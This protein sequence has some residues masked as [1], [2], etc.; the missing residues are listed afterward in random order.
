MRQNLQKKIDQPKDK[1]FLTPIVFFVCVYF[2][3][4]LVVESKLI[5]HSFGMFCKTP[6]FSK[7]MSFFTGFLQYPGGIIDYISAMLSQLYYHSYLGALIITLVAVA[8]YLCTKKLINFAGGGRSLNFVCYIPVFMMLI[9]YN[10]YYHSLTTYLAIL[11][12]LLFSVVHVKISRRID[13]LHLVLFVLEFI[14]LYYVAAGVASLFVIIT[15]AYE[16]FIRRRLISSMLFL[17]TV[18]IAVWF[19]G[20]YYFQLEIAQSCLYLTPFYK[21][22]YIPL[23]KNPAKIINICLYLF[24]PVA[25]LSVMLWHSF[26][27]QKKSVPNNNVGSY[28]RSRVVVST[29][30]LVITS[31]ATVYLSFN[32]NA[33]A[34]RQTIYL[35][36]HKMWSEL[37]AH[38]KNL[39]RKHHHLINT[40]CANRALY[41]T[42]RLAEDMFSYPQ[43]SDSLFSLANIIIGIYSR[44]GSSVLID[45]GHINYAEKRV[46]ESL[47]D[48]GENP[49]LLQRLILIN[50]V[51]G[52]RQT[53]RVFL[54]VLA[55]DLI[56]GK[57]AK[58]I[59]HRLDVDPQLIINKK[60][61]YLRSI[62]LTEGLI[63]PPQQKEETRE[64]LLLN[65]LKRNR[66]NK[67]AFEYLMA[68]Y[69]LA[70]QLDKFVENLW[71]LDDFNY[72]KIPR[73]YEEA[74]L[75]YSD[76]TGKKVD[77]HGRKISS[78]SFNRFIEFIDTLN[79]F[80]PDKEAAYSALVEN[81][82][83]SYL[84]YNAFGVS[85]VGK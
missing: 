17:V 82:G 15:I 44:V 30:V 62:M 42:G 58:E 33:K 73:H 22:T 29:A 36:E 26:F 80:Q 56:Y 63:F 28:S 31:L 5:Y 32:G 55:K 3:L 84:F 23:A 11:T 50:L 77:L 45:L 85:G 7:G 75:F 57:R 39:P 66:Y 70:N 38:I 1:R 78:F 12:A 20:Y 51:K 54:N 34:S 79:R 14:I 71:R 74:I 25:L 76:F 68:D 27:R 8:L 37:L 52:Q 18:L 10:N 49:F 60:I 9:S 47:E 21:M 4:R 40:R 48:M 24:F 46:Y 6:A 64:I 61:R 2:Y 65:L 69:L 13:S 41:H 16:L 53:A 72:Q 43:G 19:I 35:A 67:M 83:R 59:L 81:F